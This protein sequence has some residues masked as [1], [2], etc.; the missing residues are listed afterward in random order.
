MR[1]ATRIGLIPLG[2]IALSVIPLF[3][4]TGAGSIDGRVFDEQKGAMPG[5]TITARSA[6]TGRIRTTTSGATGSFHLESLPSGAW[7][8]TAEIHGFTPQVQK[9][10]VVQVD[11][12]AHLDFAMKVGS[13]SESI[14][15]TAEVPLLQTTRSDVGQ[16]ITQTMVENIPLNGRKFQDLSLLVPG[17]RVSNGYDPT[18]TEVGGVSYGGL[19]PR[20][21]NIMVDG[22]DNNDGVV[23]GLL[24]QFSADAIQEYKVTTER[25]SAEFGRSTGG[26]VDV[27]TKSGTNEFHGTGFLF[28][29][30][31]TL[32]SE[33]YFEK[34][35]GTGKSPFGQQETGGTFGG[36]LSKNRAFFFVSYEYNRRQDYTTVY[37]NGVLP[38][39]EGPQLKPFRDHLV[40]VKADWQLPSNHHLMVRYGLEDQ[41]KLHD[42][43]GGHTLRTGGASNTNLIDSIVA[44][45]SAVI[46]SSMLNEFAAHYQYFHNSIYAE[47]PNEPAMTTPDFV[48]GANGNAP[49][50]TITKRIQLK[51]DFSFSKAGWGGDHQF[52]VGGEWIHTQFGGL[53]APCLSGCFYFANPIPG[54][55]PSVYLNAIADTFQGSAGSGAL[56]DKSPTWQGMPGTTGS[57]SGR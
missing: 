53:F 56:H 5:A 7:D 12:A 4:Q 51:E 52:K 31:E 21:V 8:V 24:Q 50:E 2:L 39:E 49:Q 37:T 55:D 25:W 41:H 27:I 6:D 38:S 3:A 54:S 1:L 14:V 45:D 28:A 23:R 40:T 19:G 42:F 30:N 15:V 17:T 46:G 18:K 47:D 44:R 16:V 35:A 22:G 13:L 36:P 26:I 32:N 43:I 48:F 9:A 34:A 10:V 11:T 29:R 33:T 57:H 20:S